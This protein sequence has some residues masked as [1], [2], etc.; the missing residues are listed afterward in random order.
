M[1]TRDARAGQAETRTPKPPN[2]NKREESP[3]WL[4]PKQVTRPLNN[5]AREQEEEAIRYALGSQ[6]K[7]QGRGRPKTCNETIAERVNSLED[8]IETSNSN[9]QITKLLAELLN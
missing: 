5:Y 1:P 7:R 8:K 2:H 9:P 3:P 4:Q 6:T